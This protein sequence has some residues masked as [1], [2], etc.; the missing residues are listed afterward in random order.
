MD[1]KDIHSFFGPSI[2]LLIGLA[3]LFFGKSRM[4]RYGV[5][6]GIDLLVFGNYLPSQSG[7]VFWATL[8]KMYRFHR[9]ERAS[10]DRDEP[11]DP[12]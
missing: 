8:I 6:D 12:S 7:M 11:A 5:A 10:R 4:S 9:R 1:A 2:A 3:L